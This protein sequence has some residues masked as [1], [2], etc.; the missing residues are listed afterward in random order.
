MTTLPDISALA[1]KADLECLKSE[2]KA[3][4]RAA[5]RREDCGL[6]PELRT[7]IAELKADIII[8]QARTATVVFVSLAFLLA[9]STVIR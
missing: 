5:N 8:S 2:L 6:S 7:A 1:T 4:I 9:M 3:E